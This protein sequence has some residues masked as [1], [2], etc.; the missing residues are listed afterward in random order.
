MR[1]FASLS[2]KKDFA[3]LRARGRRMSSANLA[4]FLGDPS[5][6]DPAPLVGISVPK[7]VGN[8]VKRNLVRRRLSACVHDALSNDARLRVLILARPGAA[9]ATFAALRQEVFRALS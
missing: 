8:A 1:R 2:R 5:P 3:R 4:V 7:A 9:E 6:A